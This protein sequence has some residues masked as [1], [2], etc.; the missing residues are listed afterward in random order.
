MDYCYKQPLEPIRRYLS[1]YGLVI[2]KMTGMILQ[3]LNKWHFM[4]IVTWHFKVIGNILSLDF[5]HKIASKENFFAIAQFIWNYYYSLIYFC[6]I[7]VIGYI[8]LW[9][10]FCID[11]S[12]R[13]CLWIEVISDGFSQTVIWWTTL[14]LKN[15]P[16]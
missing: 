2:K 7:P 10:Y 1:G 8:H 3:V 9:N 6:D 14:A 11:K 16:Y 15:R 13:I 12:F 5:K 4:Y